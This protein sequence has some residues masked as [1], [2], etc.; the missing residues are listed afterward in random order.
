MYDVT[1]IGELLN[2]FTQTRNPEEETVS[3][4]Q[5]PGG[6]PA[7]V[8]AALAKFNRKPAHFLEQMLIDCGIHT[9]GLTFS[10]EIRT[11]LALVHLN[12]EGD[13]S[14]SFYRNPSAYMMLRTEE[15]DHEI[16]CQSKIVHFGHS[17]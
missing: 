7:N 5:N 14:F 11:T 10:N 13:R 6:A 1:A 8:L 3:F 9:H 16:L 12:E 2:D 15:V 17:R 4:V